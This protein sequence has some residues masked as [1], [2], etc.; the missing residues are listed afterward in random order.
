MFEAF[1]QLFSILSMHD[2]LCLSYKDCD[3]DPFV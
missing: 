2:T 1:N 3:S